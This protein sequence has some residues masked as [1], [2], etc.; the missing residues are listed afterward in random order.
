MCACVCLLVSVC[1]RGG[2]YVCS[3]FA[4]VW[5]VLVSEGFISA[6]L[7]SWPL[8]PS[9]TTDTRAKFTSVKDK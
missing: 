8:G 3:I 9:V 4:A 7:L 2:V 1:A 6:G 5:L